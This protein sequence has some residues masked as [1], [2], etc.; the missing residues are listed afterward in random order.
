MYCLIEWWPDYMY[1]KKL[2][3]LRTRYERGLYANRD[4]R[5]DTFIDQ[6]GKE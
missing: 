4:P 1:A 3:E 5:L 6:A 2:E